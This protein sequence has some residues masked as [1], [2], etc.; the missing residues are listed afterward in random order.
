MMLA[1]KD[2]RQIIIFFSK[3]H[4]IF[5]ALMDSKKHREFTGNSAKISRE[6]G[7]TFNVDDGYITGKNVELIPN[8]KIVQLWRANEPDWPDDHYS[9]ITIELTPIEE[10]TR[11]MFKQKEIPEDCY[12]VIKEGWST[13][14]WEPLKSYLEK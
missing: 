10:G 8:E 1:T 2:I 3:P 5:E 7:G 9:R 14:Y 12:E 11:L 6:I 4:E 13:Y